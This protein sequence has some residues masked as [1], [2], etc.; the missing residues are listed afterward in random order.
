MIVEQIYTSCLSQGSYYIESNDEVAIIDPIREID[1]YL[2]KAN[3][4]GSKIKYIFE[5]HLHADFISGHITLAKKTGADIV[6]G[7]NTETSF[8]K[9]SA[10][11]GQEFKIGDL[12]II[13]LHTPGHTLESTTYLLKDETGNDHAIFTGD[14]LFIG[15]V[16]RPDLSQ[17]TKVDAKLFAGLLYDSLRNKIMTLDDEIIIY[18]GHG[19]GSS[20]GKNLSSETIG[21]LGN[22][23]KTN[24]ALRE[25][26]TKS[27]FID[28]VLDG[29]DKPPKYFPFNVSMN[30]N[31]YDDSK[32]VLQKNLN[33]LDPDKFEDLISKRYVIVLDVR[34]QDDF[35]KAHIPN[36]IFIGLD[37]RFA[38]W[39]GEILE[40]INTPILLVVPNGREEEVI[41][42]LSRVGFDHIL[43]YLKGGIE[44]WTS[45]EKVTSSI[46]SSKASVL[47]DLE[48]KS[49]HLILDVR[50]HDEHQ[51]ESISDSLNIPLKSI[52]KSIDQINFKSI[53][54]IH[55]QGGYRSMIAASILKKN[56]IHSFSNVKEGYNSIKKA[57]LKL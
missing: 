47:K 19:E 35:A 12:T 2:E 29:L 10:K 14:T 22:Q 31:G 42:R 27:E 45:K 9:L 32:E 41:T 51:N 48:N 4:R 23:K 17:N 55:C 30:K 3:K 13:A 44:N 26:M 39:V 46:D 21:T 20:C 43:G 36:S 50:S 11:D 16:G 15:D 38:P 6:Y 18:P 52:N 53:F 54:Y 24:Y 1:S 8:N 37:G 40:D 25:N 49:K 28:E 5:T 56:G 7:P 34:H 57:S 33:P